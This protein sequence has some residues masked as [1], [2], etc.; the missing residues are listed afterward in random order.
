MQCPKIA[1]WYFWAPDIIQLN[2][3]YLLY[4]SVS[5]FGKNTSAIALVTNSTLDPEDPKFGWAD[6]GVVVQSR[7]TNE[8]NAID[9]AVFQDRDGSAWMSFG[10]FWSG[11]KLIQLDPQTGKRI[12]PESPLYSL[13]HHDSIEAPFIYRHEGRY[14]LFVNWGI[15]CRGTNSTYEIRMGRADSV[16]GPYVDRDGKDLLAGGGTKLLGTED[17]FIGPGHP[18]IWRENG[19]HWFSFHFYNGAQRGMST[20]AIRPLSWDAQGWPEV[21]HVMQP[22]KPQW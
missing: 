11:I 3:R 17:V 16:T 1:A 4:Y 13:A 8:F 6:E 21:Q 7:A 15:C 14:Y 19:K 20:Y 9:P 18:G 2:G 10:S 22:G 5:S 12:A